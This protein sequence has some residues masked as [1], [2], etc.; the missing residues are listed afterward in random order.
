[1]KR[2]TLTSQSITQFGSVSGLYLI[3]YRLREERQNSF[4]YLIYVVEKYGHFFLNNNNRPH[5][6][7]M[8]IFRQTTKGFVDR[9]VVDNAFFNSFMLFTV[10]FLIFSSLIL[11]MPKKLNNGTNIFLSGVI[12][13]FLTEWSETSQQKG[14]WLEQLTLKIR[15]FWGFFF[16]FQL[17]HSHPSQ[18]LYF[19]MRSTDLLW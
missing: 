19:L 14:I 18:A 17:H 8:Y 15:I 2:F 12:Q 16:S 11:N 9:V 6:R 5:Y 4:H 7:R 3:V 10:Q 1:M 13:N